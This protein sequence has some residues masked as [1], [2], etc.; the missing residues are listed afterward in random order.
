MTAPFATL[1]GER[2]TRVRL[3][4]GAVGP[5]LAEVDLEGDPELSG[6]VELALGSLRL[7]GTIDPS[8]AG[9]HGAQR[10]V[11]VVA[12][13]GGW[14]VPVSPKAY[15]NDLGILARTI[16]ED[17]AREVGEELAAF[18]AGAERVGVAY[19][20]QAGPASRVLE[21]VAGGASWWVGYD[22]RTHVGTRAEVEAEPGTYEILEFDARERVAVLGLDDLAAV[23]IGS[24]LSD[25]LDAPQVVR[26]LEIEIGP[27]TVRAR[28]WCGGASGSR[29]R[30]ED[31]LVAIVERVTARR[32]SGLF[33][34]RV[35][36]MAADR[37]ELQAVRRA[38]GLPD[39]LPVSA[40]PGVAGTHGEL[41]PG[42]RVLV[43][44]VEGDRTR[45]VIVAFQ[46]RDVGEAWAPVS[47]TLDA[48]GASGSI[49]LGRNA[50]KTI[51]YAADV[52]GELVK[53]ATALGAAVAPPGGGT[54]TYPPGTS[55]SA[56]LSDAAI[57]TGKAVAE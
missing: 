22:G 24:V 1:A 53:I 19:V 16:A 32:L 45:P 33:E 37:V 13:A 36:R 27:D 42:A 9:T 57:G 54:L 20:R 56:P 44:F 23:G 7:S 46:G 41:T 40:W 51:A 4:I 14:G 3:S 12:G 15:A 18:T 28:A 48:T 47:L 50:S 52:R 55:Y 11:R 38:A 29:G 21:D 2:A 43:Q 25:R 26:D 49:K 10:R 39:V 8:H 17:A 34:F 35:V 30:L 31:L 5:W 6:R